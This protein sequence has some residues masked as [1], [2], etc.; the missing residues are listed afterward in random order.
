MSP[1]KIKIPSKKN[2]STQRWALEFNSDVKG[3]T[4]VIRFESFSFQ[5]PVVLE[6]YQRHL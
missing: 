2:L 6:R 1:L 4:D 5:V 3:L